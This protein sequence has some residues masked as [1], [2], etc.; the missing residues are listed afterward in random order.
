MERAY[1]VCL[2]MINLRNYEIL[3]RD[4]ERI[5]ARKPNNELMCVFLKNTYNT[6]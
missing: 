6:F 2:E 4:D 5:L 1:E 3:D